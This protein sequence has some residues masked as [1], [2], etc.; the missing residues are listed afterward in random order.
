MQQNL[1]AKAKDLVFI[2]KL[3][4]D[5]GLNFKGN[6][7][8]GTIISN[9]TKSNIIIMFSQETPIQDNYAVLVKEL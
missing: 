3:I 4:S 2:S 9:E 1:T 5:T 6:K 7:A 8:K